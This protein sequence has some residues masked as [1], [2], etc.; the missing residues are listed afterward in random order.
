[1]NP[2]DIDKE[3]VRLPNVDI[4]ERIG[5]LIMVAAMAAVRRLIVAKGT[6]AIA[7]GSIAPAMKFRH[8]SE[9]IKPNADV[10][11]TRCAKENFAVADRKAIVALTNASR[12]MSTIA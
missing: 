8:G 5:R 9:M 10:A 7:I 12:K 4:R 3:T 11:W 2:R 1:M 6:Q